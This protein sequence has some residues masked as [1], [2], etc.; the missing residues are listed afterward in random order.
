[1]IPAPF[2]YER[3]ASLD[4][5]IELLTDAADAKLLAGGQSLLP[6]M[7][8]R[9][10]RPA[11]LVDVGR[12]AELSY[13]REEGGH[14]AIGALTT[15]HD[16]ATSDLLRTACPILAS[17]ASD[18]GDPQVRHVGT[19]GGSCAHADP[20]GDLPA[21]LLA[22]GAEFLVRG[23]AG[24]TG[25]AAPRRGQCHW[26]ATSV[27]IW[28]YSGPASPRSTRASPSSRSAGVMARFGKASKSE[29]SILS[30]AALLGTL[31]RMFSTTHA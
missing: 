17:T 2:A 23:P 24:A 13:V 12:L 28:V 10:A 25:R 6:L 3:A 26:A 30:M 22:L 18:I 20:A 21:V 31:Y 7:R 11:L 1:M 29:V 4:R 16:L 14:L 8:L 27:A 5:A 15:H 19:I 9:F